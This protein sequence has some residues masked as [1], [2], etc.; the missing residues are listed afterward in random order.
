MKIGKNRLQQLPISPQTS[1]HIRF[2]VRKVISITRCD[3]QTH[4]PGANREE[5]KGKSTFFVTSAMYNEI[6][7]KFRIGLRQL[8]IGMNSRRLSR[9]CRSWSHFSAKAAAS[10]LFFPASYLHKRLPVQYKLDT[11]GPMKNESE[12]RLCSSTHFGL[13]ITIQKTIRP[14]PFYEP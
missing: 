9:D 14:R 2:H 13:L 8:I 6:E 10:K 11:I 3:D 12:P 5:G 7:R 1:S 4:E